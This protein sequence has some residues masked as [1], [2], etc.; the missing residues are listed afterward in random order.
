MEEPRDTSKASK[1]TKKTASTP[2]DQS[3]DAAASKKTPRVTNAQVAEQVTSDSVAHQKKLYDTHIGR[4][5]WT[6][7]HTQLR[8]LAEISTTSRRLKPQDARALAEKTYYKIDS[9]TFRI[10]QELF[11]TP[12]HTVVPGDHRNTAKT[13][14]PNIVSKFEDPAAHSVAG[15]L[16]TRV[17]EPLATK[18]G[19]LEPRQRTARE[20]ITDCNTPQVV[21]LAKYTTECLRPLGNRAPSRPNSVVLVVGHPSSATKERYAPIFRELG[22]TAPPDA[23][24]TI[25]YTRQ[26]SASAKR[27]TSIFPPQRIVQCFTNSFD[28]LRK[29]HEEA[30]Q[31]QKERQELASLQGSWKHFTSATLQGWISVDTLK[32]RLEVCPTEDA[33]TKVS[34]DANEVNKS[35]TDAYRTLLDRS[36]EH[37]EG[38]VHREKRVVY[39]RLSAMKAKLDGSST[40]RLNPNPVT[41]RAEANQ[42]LAQLR[43]ED[44]RVKNSYNISDQ[45]L[46][47]ER[48]KRDCDILRNSAISLRERAPLFT[49]GER[50]FTDKKMD[51][52]TR[53]VEVSRVLGKLGISRSELKEITL[54][55]FTTYRDKILSCLNSFES[56]LRPGHFSQATDTLA[57]MFFV[58]RVFGLQRNFEE[59]KVSLVR[60][61]SDLATELETAKSRLSTL[62]TMDTL[63]PTKVG[64]EKTRAASDFKEL[65]SGMVTSVTSLQNEFLEILKREISENKGMALEREREEFRQR[66]LNTLK[67]FDPEQFM[68]TVK[69]G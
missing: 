16:Y 40:G 43:A 27:D 64:I 34:Q 3:C 69:V 29:T 12:E 52:I 62:I 56:H 53:T 51:Q 46:I 36:L 35:I 38:S 48:I 5:S 45:G 10:A 41:L 63:F 37:F 33:K 54:R 2:V 44:I 68:K 49:S 11:V 13:Q 6:A 21:A 67:G 58:C 31:Y 24:G 1:R 65:V 15:L 25:W 14:D 22:I 61:D 66:A 8:E 50:V 4:G 18:M 57:S 20:V 28:A 26:A 9:R 60:S 59:L 17:T 7:N 19:W 42:A 47:S 30:N 23:V 32:Q 55:P 39:N